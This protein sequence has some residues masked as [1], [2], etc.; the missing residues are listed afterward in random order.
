MVLNH[1]D[2]YIIYIG[3][4][5]S[6]VAGGFEIGKTSAFLDVTSCFPNCTELSVYTFVYS[7]GDVQK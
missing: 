4:R 2:Q 7:C 1:E 6:V 5:P 3:I